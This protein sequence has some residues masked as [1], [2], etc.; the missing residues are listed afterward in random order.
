MTPAE[1]EASY[2]GATP[3]EAFETFDAANVDN[4]PSPSYRA[5]RWPTSTPA[6]FTQI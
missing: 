6:G 2:A 1:I 3:D 5:R 4:A